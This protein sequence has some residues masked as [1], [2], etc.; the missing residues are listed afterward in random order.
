LKPPSSPRTLSFFFARSAV[1][2]YIETAKYF[3]AVVRRT[4]HGIYEF[5][6][7]YA[8]FHDTGSFIQ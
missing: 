3:N 4:I 1:K 7:K 5:I 8:V 6:Q 2:L